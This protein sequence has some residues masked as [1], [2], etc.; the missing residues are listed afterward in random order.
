MNIVPKKNYFFPGQQK[1]V[2]NFPII[3]TFRSG[4]FFKILLF[5]EKIVKIRIF[6]EKIAK[7]C[8]FRGKN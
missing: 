1:I 3:F 7:I 4:K 5:W 8:K 6:K 2:K